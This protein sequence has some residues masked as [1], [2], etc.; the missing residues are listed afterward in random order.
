MGYLA[1]LRLTF[2]FFNKVSNNL[3]WPQTQSISED[4]LELLMVE[5]QTVQILGKEFSLNYRRISGGWIKASIPR[6]PVNTVPICEKSLP[7]PL[8]EGT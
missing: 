8:A 7:S 3:G 2:F 6:V 4:D 1:D 5:S